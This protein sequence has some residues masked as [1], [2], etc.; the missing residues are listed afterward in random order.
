ME[1]RALQ[2]A[3]D[4]QRY[5]AWARARLIAHSVYLF[6]PTAKGT[7]KETDPKVFFPLPGDEDELPEPTV[8]HIS[9][10]DIKELNR[11]KE[12]IR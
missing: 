8:I 5:D 10:N 7:H 11:I 3:K 2:K 1:L 4:Q 9:E 12:L 6:A